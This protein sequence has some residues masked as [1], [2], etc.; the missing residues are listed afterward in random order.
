MHGERQGS[1]Q[2]GGSVHR[3]SSQGEAVQS[4]GQNWG[5]C[6]SRQC[7]GSLE[8]T[9]LLPCWLERAG[10]GAAQVAQVSGFLLDIDDRLLVN[11]NSLWFTHQPQVFEA[12]PSGMDRMQRLPASSRPAFLSGISSC[13]WPKVL[14]SSFNESCS[15]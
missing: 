3:S 6:G 4:G 14:S 9:C 13:W 1:Q 2:S 12:D 10:S 5:P 11:W 7:L 8:L 15:S